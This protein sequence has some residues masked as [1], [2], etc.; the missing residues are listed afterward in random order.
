MR[1]LAT[2][3]VA[4]L[5]L[6]Q[7]ICTKAEAGTIIN[8]TQGQWEVTGS[9]TANWNGSDL[10]FESQ[11]ANGTDFEITGYFDW[12][13]NQ[14]YRGRELFSGTYTANGFLNFTG[15][16]LINPIAIQLANYQAEVL[17]P[18]QIGNGTWRGGGISGTWVATNPTAILEPNP[19]SVTVPEPSSVFSLGI[20]AVAGTILKWY[21]KRKAL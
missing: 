16:Q 1:S 8:L 4:C 7:S 2:T 13:S 17:S 20:V 15:F 19:D 3:A 14:T 6:A 5:L 21:T 11:V 9:D 12:Y 10:F 18:S